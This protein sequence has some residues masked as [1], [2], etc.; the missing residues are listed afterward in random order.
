MENN[1]LSE[2]EERREER[3]YNGPAKRLME[4]LKPLSSHVEMYQKRWFWE[5]LQNACDNNDN[6]KIQVE[7]TKEYLKFR[8]NGKPFTIKD[9]LNLIFPDSGK[10]NID[11]PSVIGQFGTGFLSTHIIS[12]KVNVEGILLDKFDEKYPFS[13]NLNRSNH[14]DKEFLASALSLA[15]QELRNSKKGF[16]D[17][18]REYQTQFTY[19]LNSTFEFSI[20]DETIKNGIQFIKSALPY[21]FSFVDQLQRV[22]IITTKNTF[23]FT[24][25]DG[26]KK[27][28][29]YERIGEDPITLECLVI[30]EQIGNTRV[31]IRVNGNEVIA[32]NEVPFLFCAYP[33]LGTESFPFPCVINSPELIPKTER[34]GI[35]LSEYDKINR[36]I[37]EDAVKAYL[38]LLKKLCDS[39]FKSIY[40]ACILKSNGFEGKDQEWFKKSI[41]DQ[42]KFAI[43]ENDVV[44]T[45][46]GKQKLKNVSIP[47][48]EN[49]DVFDAYYSICERTSF[50]IPIKSEA[51]S[52]YKI[53]NFTVFTNEKLDIKSLVEKVCAPSTKKIYESLKQETNSIKW[54]VDAIIYI[55]QFEHQ[56]LLQKHAL[57]P[58]KSEN[59][60]TL[61]NEI[62]WDDNIS[63]DLIEIHDLLHSNTYNDI[64]LHSE[65]EII[66]DKLWPLDKKKTRADISKL[67]DESFNSTIHFKIT[68][69]FVEALQKLFIWTDSMFDEELLKLFPIFSANKAKLI[70]DT[71]GTD[72]ERNLAFDIIRSD[73]KEILSRIA[74]SKITTKELETIIDNQRDFLLFIAWKNSLVDDKE[75]ASEDLGDIG[76]KYLH[77]W[78]LKKYNGK[79]E[80]EVEWVAKTR[81]EPNY[82]FEV[83][84]N[85]MP[86]IFIDAKTTNR[87][88]SN[89]DSIPFFMRK[90]QWD[91]LPKME[92]EQIYFIARVF[93]E[94]ETK[95]NH[96][97]L[98]IKPEDLNVN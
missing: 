48:P 29:K 40:N 63:Q 61:K 4:K 1:L 42:L 28:C 8:H 72:H 21:V 9:A 17:E 46:I 39:N 23:I 79:A 45:S 20:I 58:V 62:Y 60:K 85:G 56:I 49:E 37:I 32:N 47:S 2:F 26:E 93:V 66:G 19:D 94:D 44:S 51:L 52:W 76:E 24:R 96:R 92:K 69:S 36:A 54:L 55:I 70:L 14:T 88:I 41:S 68:P 38:S 65:I 15:E 82:D 64:L 78:L 6:V 22:E 57:I 35:E 12:S 91:F 77:D 98:N 11:D 18:N 75:N 16:I 10:D 90:G 87:G 84:K 71:L 89:S 27:G 7:I 30:S 97:F 86:W 73:K 53:L 81:S 83:R 74:N 33:M 59:L 31:A 5:L 43:L 67:I 50:Q 80:Y 3:L 13:F 95:I 25:L 34:D